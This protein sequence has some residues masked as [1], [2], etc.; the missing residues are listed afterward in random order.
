MQGKAD[1]HVHT[2]YSGVH[3]MGV[4]RFPES[5]SDPR[6]VLS[7]A[8]ACG[9]NVVCITDHNSIIGA[10]KTKALAKDYPGVEVVVGEEVSTKDGELLALFIDEVIPEGLSAAETVRLVREQGGLT[11][12]PHPYSLHCP[13]L[14][15]KIYSLDLDGIEVF[16]GGHIDD[17]SNRMAQEAG[18]EGRWATVAGSDSHYLRTLGTTYTLFEGTTAEDLRKAILNKATSWRGKAIPLNHAVAWSISV[19]LRSD[20]LIMRS[21]VH[22]NG[23]EDPDDP[24]VRKVEGMR[25]EQKLAAF[26]G[27]SIYLIPPIPFIVAW[28]SQRMF[29]RMAD[30]ERSNGKEP[31]TKPLA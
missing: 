25:A 16:N 7:K 21:L 10:K 17:Y 22:K 6:D 14:G 2:K 1:V 12:A 18:R 29:H 28:I 9:L 11:I 5:A 27:S 31:S 19:V 20:L 24:V 30:R 23:G 3:R 4:L 15:E 8:Q 26:I 13:C